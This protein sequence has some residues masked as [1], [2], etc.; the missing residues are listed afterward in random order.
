MLTQVIWVLSLRRYGD[1]GF[2]HDLVVEFKGTHSRFLAGLVSVKG[3]DYFTTGAIIG[4]EPTGDS[5]VTLP[6]SRSTCRHCRRDSSKV[7][8]HNIGIAFDDNELTFPSHV[9]LR[10][11]QSIQNLGFLIK[12]RFG[13]IEVLGSISIGS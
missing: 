12:A 1:E 8:S 5:H 10:Q 2:R 4:D 7:C 13:R 9:T 11:I 3:K 6:K